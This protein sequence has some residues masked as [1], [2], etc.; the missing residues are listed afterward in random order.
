MKWNKALIA[1]VV[2]GVVLAVYDFIMFGLIMGSTLEKYTIFRT[3]SNM[4]WY[5]VLAILMGIVGG[6]FFAKSRSSWPAGAKGGATFGFWVG[7]IGFIASFYNSLTF[8]GFQYYLD[9]CWGS[10][11]LIGW[12][13]AGA[14]FG[15]LYKE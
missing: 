8:V 3:D 10:T 7:L 4:I 6:L 1:G 2:G 13:L 15:A 14:A 12:I 9:W 11:T 5:P